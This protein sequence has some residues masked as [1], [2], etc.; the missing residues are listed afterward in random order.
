MLAC[1]ATQLDLKNHY[2]LKVSNLLWHR[3]PEK[4]CHLTYFQRPSVWR[5]MREN[6]TLSVTFHLEPDRL[7]LDSQ[8]STHRQAISSH[9]GHNTS[10]WELS[11]QEERKFRLHPAATSHHQR[12]VKLTPL[13]RCIWFHRTVSLTCVCPVLYFCLLRKLNRQINLSNSEAM[14]NIEM[15]HDTE[16]LWVK[17]KEHQEV[18]NPGGLEREPGSCSPCHT[19][20]YILARK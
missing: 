14:G 7:T 19:L 8:G 3:R 2:W 18:V 1:P 5:S 17:A 13:A 4:L 11:P 16:A 9:R 6:R 20:C 15:I 10:V 12:R